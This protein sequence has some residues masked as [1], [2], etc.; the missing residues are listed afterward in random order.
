MIQ[1]GIDD[2]KWTFTPFFYVYQTLIVVP[3]IRIDE[4]HALLSLLQG[5]CNLI[6]IRSAGCRGVVAVAGNAAIHMATCAA[7]RIAGVAGVKL[8]FRRIPNGFSGI[9]S[10]RQA[11]DKGYAAKRGYYGLQHR[12]NFR[13]KT[14]P[15]PGLDSYG[16]F[17][18]TLVEYSL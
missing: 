9:C 17:I 13:V 14:M 3:D 15:A 7:I 10:R 16:C 4:L 18:G 6:A 1:N 8:M 12:F 11:Y 5:H 2:R